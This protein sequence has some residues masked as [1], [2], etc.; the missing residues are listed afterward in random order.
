MH[1]L[2]ILRRAASFLPIM[3]E[4]KWPKAGGEVALVGECVSIHRRA[5]RPHAGP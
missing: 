5:V 2:P 4:R 3:K 1:R